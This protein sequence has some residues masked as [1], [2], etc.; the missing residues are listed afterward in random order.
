VKGAAVHCL[1]I[2]KTKCWLISDHD[3]PAPENQLENKLH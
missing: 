1:D 2:S 3:R